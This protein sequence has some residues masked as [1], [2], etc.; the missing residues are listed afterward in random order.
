[1]KGGGVEWVRTLIMSFSFAKKYCQPKQD[2][3]SV[4]RHITLHIVCAMTIHGLSDG[5]F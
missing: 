2:L 3:C 4:Y 1:M 5:L